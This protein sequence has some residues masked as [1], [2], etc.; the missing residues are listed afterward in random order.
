LLVGDLAT[1]GRRAA[2]AHQPAWEQLVA[3]NVLA[4][5]GDA[6]RVPSW[7]TVHESVPA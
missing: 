6:A 5:L 3:A 7:L 4:R 2:G 1:F